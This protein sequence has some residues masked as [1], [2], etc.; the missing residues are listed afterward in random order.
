MGLERR[1]STGAKNHQPQGVGRTCPWW[2]PS[3]CYCPKHTQS[4]SVLCPAGPVDSPARRPAHSHLPSPTKPS[5]ACFWAESCFTL[6]PYTLVHP[7]RPSQPRP[8]IFVPRVVGKILS[9]KL[10]LLQGFKKCPA[11][12]LSLGGPTCRSGGGARPWQNACLL[13][14]EPGGGYCASVLGLP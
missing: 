10:C 12:T 11:G 1:R 14:G 13:S 5:T 6:V 8:V 7:H 4:V 9:E 2:E 3:L